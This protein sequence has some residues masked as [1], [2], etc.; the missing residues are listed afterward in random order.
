M[1]PTCPTST[2]SRTCAPYLTNLMF[3]GNWL[4]LGA[5]SAML[6]GTTYK[7]AAQTQPYSLVKD[8]VAGAAASS[9]NYFTPGSVGATQHTYFQAL[10][11]DSTQGI[12]ATDGT[13]NTTNLVYTSN[14][15]TFNVNT[16]TYA[17][18]LKPLGV[19]GQKLLF[20]NDIASYYTSPQREGRRSLLCSI[21]EANGNKVDTLA[22]FM[23]CG[24][25]RAYSSSLRELRTD[26]VLPAAT[27]NG[28]Y[29]FFA[30]DS[31]SRRFALWKTDGTK[32]GTKR[33]HY[34]NHIGTGMPVFGGVVYFI[35]NEDDSQ[36]VKIWTS[37]GY[38]TDT[39]AINPS[40]PAGYHTLFV[41]AQSLF[42]ASDSTLYR[43]QGVANVNAQYFHSAKYFQ[44]SN[45]QQ[46]NGNA[47]FV[48]SKRYDKQVGGSSVSTIDFELYRIDT[49][50]TLLLKQ[51]ITGPYSISMSGNWFYPWEL[52]PCKVLEAQNHLYLW[53]NIYTD[54]HPVAGV[55]RFWSYDLLE[56]TSPSDT[57]IK[58]PLL[59]NVPLPSSI[60]QSGAVNY[61]GLVYYGETNEKANTNTLYRLSP[62]GNGTAAAPAV[63]ITN[64]NAPADIYKGGLSPSVDK[65]YFVAKTSSLGSEPY[66]MRDCA[67]APRPHLSALSADTLHRNAVLTWSVQPNGTT[68]TQFDIHRLH[69]GNDKVVA[70]IPYLATTNTY[71]YTDTL[72]LVGAYTYRIQVST[73]D[74]CSRTDSTSNAIF[75]PCPT[76]PV[77]VAS[78]TIDTTLVNKVRFAV[79]LSQPTPPPTSFTMSLLDGY[80]NYYVSANPNGVYTAEH[81]PEYQKPYK[82]QIAIYPTEFA[83]IA[84]KSNIYRYTL[85]CP[86]FPTFSGFS[87][88]T[89]GGNVKVEWNAQGGSSYLTDDLLKLRLIKNTYLPASSIHWADYAIPY[90]AGHHSFTDT[91]VPNGKHRYWLELSVGGASG[92]SAAVTPADTVDV[93][94]SPLPHITETK[95]DTISGHKVR[96]RWRV[97][98]RQTPIRNISI[99]RKNVPYG[100]WVEVA[101][102]PFSNS[103]ATYEYIEHLTDTLPHH[104]HVVVNTYDRCATATSSEVVGQFKRNQIVQNVTLSPN[105]TNGVVSLYLPQHNLT[106][107]ASVVFY[108]IDGHLML[109]QTN[110]PHQTVFD[111]SGW[112]SGIYVAKVVQGDDVYI[113]RLVK[114]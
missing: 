69:Y 85:P 70:S 66:V 35:A 7:A 105:P 95:L 25:I 82:Y 77:T 86:T 46:D 51:P 84:A 23:E 76:L 101:N 48:N 9:P 1:M 55:E 20:T 81:S 88:D 5:F 72:H 14:S 13:A 64:P 31:V 94:C 111:I 106:P 30:R 22:G 39:S 96:L 45:I 36:P 2:I 113:F 38:T 100:A 42:I 93:A 103:A 59:H 65:L 58:T 54:T 10:A 44:L 18:Y 63:I 47:Y 40:I 79:T 52:G 8:V 74:V 97:D 56:R 87:A 12:F 68:P 61:Q 17:R 29:F 24:I 28:D 50:A 110:V 27:L 108:D 91:D 102:I 92:C 109:E 80:T 67:T 62:K 98:D 53:R 16:Y 75:I 71:T 114:R 26:S 78:F 73:T 49:T 57:F 6:V 90:T 15:R 89:L 83:C 32:N 37:D 21:D 4:L 107:V 34:F 33:L 99:E 104:F 41:A 19:V 60:Y 112:A 43:S 11:S 3:G